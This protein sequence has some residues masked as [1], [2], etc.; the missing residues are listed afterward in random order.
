[1]SRVWNRSES[2]ASLRS[3]R[4]SWPARWICGRRGHRALPHPNGAMRYCTRCGAT[5]LYNME[6]PNV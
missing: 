2:A 4:G 5:Q 1:M 3:D 6:A